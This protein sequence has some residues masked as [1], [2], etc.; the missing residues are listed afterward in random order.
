LQPGVYF[1][2]GTL[3]GSGLYV[4]SGG[5]V[6]TGDCYAAGGPTQPN[7][8]ST[9]ICGITMTP[10]VGASNVFHCGAG[11]D[12]GVLLVFW[13]HGV[14]MACVAGNYPNASYPFC[15]YVNTNGNDNQLHIQGGANLYITSSPRYHSVVVHVNPAHSNSSWNFTLPA[16]LPAGFT[17]QTDA[18]QLGNGS[19]VVYING[20]GSIS[21][22]GATFAPQDNLLLGGASGGKGYGQLLAFYI[23]Y[24]GNATINEGYNPLALVY[25]PV[26]VR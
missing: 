5:T 13:P 15:G 8:T 25:S 20:G 19:N 3:A 14:D 16:T 21:V 23:H 2:E 7:C 17:T 24:Q 22:V 18:G 12:M 1:F 9:A 26:I 11:N 4:T 10:L 6:V